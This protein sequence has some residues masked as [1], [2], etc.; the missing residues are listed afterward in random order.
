MFIMYKI[1]HMIIIKQIKLFGGLKTIK[2]S[3]E[4]ITIKIRKMVTY[5]GKEV[6]VMGHV[7]DFWSAGNGLCLDLDVCSVNCHIYVVCIFL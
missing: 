5:G 6:A 7:R 2:K 1:I 4:I 3:T